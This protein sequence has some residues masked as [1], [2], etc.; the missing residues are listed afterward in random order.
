MLKHMLQQPEFDTCSSLGML[1][2]YL[3]AALRVQDEL[4]DALSL[5]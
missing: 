2:E 1:A 3:C 5:S 4:W